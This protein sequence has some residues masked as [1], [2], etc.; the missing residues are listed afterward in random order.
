MNENFLF[1]PDKT[2]VP[3]KK[4]KNTKRN[5]KTDCEK[6]GLYEGCISPKMQPTG[7]YSRKILFIA[8]APGREEDIRGT[9]LV[10]ESGK[11]LRKELEKLNIDLEN[12]L[13]TNAIICRPPKNKTPT[14]SQI[15][16][17]RKNI[18]ETIKKYKP[19]II[20]LLGSI[21]HKSLLGKKLTG[22][23]NGTEYSDWIGS[24]IPD[25]ELNTWILPIYHPSFLLR[26]GAEQNKC[27]VLLKKWRRQLKNIL[28]YEDKSVPDYYADQN[29][30]KIIKNEKEACNFLDFLLSHTFKIPFAFDYETTGIKPQRK[31]QKII[32]VSFSDGD[33]SVAFPVF[34]SVTFL[35]KLKEV[36]THKYIYFIAH[37]LKYEHLWTLNKL[38]ISIKNWCWDTK[39]AEHC[40]QNKK[41]NTG[42]K[43]L[44]YQHFGILG[45]DEK[46][47]EY[48][49]S[50][51]KNK[52]ANGI[53]HI[54]KANINDVLYYNA[55]DSLYTYW[56]Y[57]I[58]RKKLSDFQIE[59]LKLFISGAKHL[60]EATEEGFKMDKEQFD[61]VEEQI[62]D[63][64]K[65]INKYI[66]NSNEVKKWDWKEEFNFNSPKHLKH[67]LYD[68]LGLEC[69]QVTEKGNKKVSQDVLEEM[70]NGFTKQ[71]VRHKKWNKAQ[72]TY[73]AQYKREMITKEGKTK[74]HPFFNLTTVRSFRSSSSNPNVQNVPK[75]NPKIK[76]LIRSFIIPRMN[77]RLVA[78]DYKAMEVSIAACYNKDKNLIEYVSD[79]KLDMHRD[80]AAV[81]FKKEK[82]EVDKKNERD[83]I[84]NTFVFPAFYGSYY[85]QMAPDIWDR[86]TKDTYN[87]LKTK[88]IRNYNSFEKHV[89]DIENWFWN[90]MF[91]GY[92]KWKKK[93]LSDYNKRGY[94][95]LYTGFR[96]YGPMKD[97]EVINIA[98]QGSAFH[99]LLWAFNRCMEHKNEFESSY[100]IGEIHDEIVADINPAEEDMFDY[101]VWYYG[102]QKIREYWDWIIVPLFIEKERSDI[103]GCWAGMNEVGFLDFNKE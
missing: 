25:Q 2:E 67:L 9:Q 5:K 15:N 23:I 18:F 77:N 42:L 56:L 46:I 73:L 83:L 45:Y 47:D 17:C 100:L 84:K 38:N 64:L 8:E 31:M 44:V 81:L 34:N 59:G 58:Q 53:N 74:I 48:L 78:Y 68:I 40:I 54:E 57:E 75:R 70:N 71:I 24:I 20:V 37:N 10:G 22:K 12:C 97:N 99:C 76:N 93:L 85:A 14:V 32:S 79:P 80:I 35:K 55:L 3:I 16:K 30:I 94:I 63:K 89:Q 60:T 21:A 102:T 91:P 98:I 33:Y 92:K 26:Q 52:G 43:F 29:K 62:N 11:L 65:N 86:M 39:L 7:K 87:W 13:K 96:C 36:F 4:K 41:K 101:I 27:P 66:Q 82:N 95:D 50:S 1:E 61:K 49:K 103:N 88:G 90:D 6:C 28:R 51:E 19:H 69:T 72:T